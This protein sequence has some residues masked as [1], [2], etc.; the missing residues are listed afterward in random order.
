MTDSLRS[1]SQRA[2]VDAGD[3]SDT[4]QVPT[5]GWWASMPAEARTGL[6]AVL[7]LM[8][9]TMALVGGVGCLVGQ[10]TSLGIGIAAASIVLGI[11]LFTIGVLFGLSNG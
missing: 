11:V 2:Q 1:V 4:D 5:K 8:M 3:D 7:F 9:A 6:L 10:L